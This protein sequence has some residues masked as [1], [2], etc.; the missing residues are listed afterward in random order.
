[1]RSR[2]EHELALDENPIL[3]LFRF[4]IRVI[5]GIKKQFQEV[6]IQLLPP[7]RRPRRP[8]IVNEIPTEFE[9]AADPIRPTKSTV[10]I[11][12]GLR[13][14]KLYGAGR[15]PLLRPAPALRRKNNLSPLVQMGQIFSE[16]SDSLLFASL[17]HAEEE[18]RLTQLAVMMAMT[19]I[20]LENF[21]ALALN[22]AAA[23]EQPIL[24]AVEFPNLSVPSLRIQPEVP[25]PQRLFAP[26]YYRPA[27][28][29]RPAAMQVPGNDQRLSGVNFPTDLIPEEFKCELVSTVMDNPV[30]LP[31]TNQICDGVSVLKA[32]AR[33]P[34]NPFNRQPMKMDDAQSELGLRSK[35]K[36]YVDQVVEGV[37]NRQKELDGQPLTR[38][39][40]ESIHSDVMGR[41]EA[42]QTTQPRM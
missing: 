7:R 4:S 37:Q 23:R 25:N 39:D 8:L 24:D 22:K 5:N 42:P 34:E 26:H 10:L 13:P 27:T 30:R 15:K 38:S 21:T 6:T 16:L 20:L 32:L 12:N 31:L 19:M 29:P 14:V 1:M 11:L 40:Y 41:L 35:I 18:A 3:L 17:L 36:S 28:P 2:P 33:K 9:F